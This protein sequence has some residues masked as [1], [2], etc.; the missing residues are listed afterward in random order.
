[1]PCTRL[2]PQYDARRR[3]SEQTKAFDGME[4]LAQI[5]EMR[6]KQKQVDASSALATPLSGPRTVHFQDD[7][8]SDDIQSDAG[9]MIA[10]SYIAFISSTNSKIALPVSDHVRRPVT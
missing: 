8:G 4:V 1:M 9:A 10:G 3:I 7:D 2:T 5:C 6:A